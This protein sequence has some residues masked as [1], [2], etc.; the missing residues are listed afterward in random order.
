MQIGISGSI[1]GD[2]EVYQPQLQVAAQEKQSSHTTTKL[3]KTSL[4]RTSCWHPDPGYHKPAPFNAQNTLIASFGRR[5][6]ASTLITWFM[7]AITVTVRQVRMIVII[8][9]MMILV[10]TTKSGKNCYDNPC[11]ET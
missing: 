3:P 1:L 5:H 8:I 11:P 9:M 7:L 2:R 10:V 6:G 4:R